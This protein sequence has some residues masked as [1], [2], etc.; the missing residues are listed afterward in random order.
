MS[1]N[2]VSIVGVTGYTGMELL[3]CLLKHD[4]VELK[5]LVSRQ[6]DGT[7]LAELFPRLAHIDAPQITNTDHETVATE[8]DIVFLCERNLNDVLTIC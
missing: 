1:K 5:Y 4:H 3:R 8:S 6:H 7:P 2:K